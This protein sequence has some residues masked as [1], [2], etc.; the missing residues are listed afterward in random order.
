MSADGQKVAIIT[1]AGRNVGYATAAALLEVGFNVVVAENDEARGQQAADR[2][3]EAN[4]GDGFAIY[5]PCDVSSETSVAA[6]VDE[7]VARFGSVTVL[8][9]NVAIT[10]RGAT[11]LTLESDVWDSVLAVTL[12]SVFNCTKH[13][14]KAMVAGGK[15]GVVV[16]VGSTSAHVGRKNALAYGVAKAGVLSLTRSSAVQLGEHG[17]RVVAVSPNKVGS[18]VGED[19]EPTDRKRT[20]VLGRGAVPEDIAT[21]IRFI[22]SDEAGFITGTELFVDGGASITSG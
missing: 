13:A 17:I 1:G 22:V 10:D 19:E 9:N 11:V 2:L 16:N 5:L 12:T 21:A 15:G 7:T 3:N 6:L 4:T 18:P 14:A 8:V 20:N